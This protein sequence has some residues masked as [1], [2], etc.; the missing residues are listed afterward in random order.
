MCG[1]A[2]SMLAVS[3]LS[4][5]AG[6]VSANNAAEA[7]MQSAA[8][9]QAIQNQQLS[10]QMTQTQQQAAQEALT[11]R[12]QTD[13]ELATAIAAAGASGVSGVSLARQLGGIGVTET[14]DLGVIQANEEARLQQAGVGGLAIKQQFS[15]RVSSAKAS[16]PSYLEA[17][18]SIAGQGLG[19]YASGLTIKSAL[20]K[21]K[22]G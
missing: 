9:A 21:R 16:A 14:M 5:A 6:A 10:M 20:D 17:G 13:R 22:G 11:R 19:G 1:I 8:A 18:L 7:Q 4:A 12:Q 2:E 3:A 15:D